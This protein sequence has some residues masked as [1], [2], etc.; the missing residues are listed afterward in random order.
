MDVLSNVG[1]R[2][3]DIRKSKNLSQQQ[4]ADLART[5]YSYIGD[6]ERG[7]RNITLQSLEKIASALE[8]DI[9]DF[10]I[11]QYHSKKSQSNPTLVEIMDLLLE[12]N[13]TNQKKVLNILKEVFR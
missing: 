8:V 13:E 3:R 7:N 6:L 10:F 2:I 9:S 12:I 5:H 11:Y 1:N 4:L